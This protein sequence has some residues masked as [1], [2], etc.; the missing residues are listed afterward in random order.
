MKCVGCR[1]GPS[2][3]YINSVEK[4]D[5][6]RC[7]VPSSTGWWVKESTQT[8][9][10]SQYQSR[11][12][13]RRRTLLSHQ[14]RLVPYGVPEKMIGLRFLQT[15]WLGLRRRTNF[16]PLKSIVVL[17]KQ[18][19]LFHQLRLLETRTS[20]VSC[21]HETRLYLSQSRYPEDSIKTKHPTFRCDQL[22]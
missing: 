7:L 6:V 4:R 16:N 5:S 8:S 20:V 19:S 11:H 12:R 3:Y 13:V 2:Y 18:V 17:S 9:F 1:T 15:P 22:S 21:H 14:S 10:S